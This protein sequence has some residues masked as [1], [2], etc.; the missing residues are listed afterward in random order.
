MA[1]RR[2]QSRMK[3]IRRKQ[4]RR[5]QIKRKQSRMKQSRRKQ[6]NR[7]RKRI[8]KRLIGGRF[9]NAGSE[10]VL[11]DQPR[12]PCIG[13]K[14]NQINYSEIGKLF[15]DNDK[16]SSNAD[17]EI[18]AS[19]ILLDIT[20]TASQYFVMTVKKC[21]INKELFITDEAYKGNWRTNS[22]GYFN[23]S[24]LTNDDIDLPPNW[25]DMVVYP[26][27]EMDLFDILSQGITFD[28]FNSILKMFKNVLNGVKLLQ[29]NDNNLFYGDF[30]IENILLIDGTLKIADIGNIQEI[31][32]HTNMKSL[33]YFYY[34]YMHPS[35]AALTYWFLPKPE[36]NPE[37]QL[38][39]ITLSIP[40]LKSLYDDSYS[41]FGIIEE[42]NFDNI[43][44]KLRSRFIDA[45][46]GVTKEKG[47]DDKQVRTV[48]AIKT[49]LLKQKLFNIK[50]VSLSFK[51]FILF[52]KNEASQVEMEVV[53]NKYLYKEYYKSFTD[54]E[55]LKIDLLKRIDLYSIGIIIL[56]IINSYIVSNPDKIMFHDLIIKLYRVVFL[57]CNQMNPLCD[58]NKI[59]ETYNYIIDEMNNPE[60]ASSK[61]SEPV[62]EKRKINSVVV[63]EQDEKENALPLNKKMGSIK[64]SISRTKSI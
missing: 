4:S 52:L 37:P 51:N 14:I 20:D 3:Q 30:S 44:D 18:F 35:I 58:I 13:E 38:N 23:N 33:P 27:G 49:E 42:K 16:G 8:S 2:K 28:D 22:E 31:N 11:Y 7:R 15:P 62:D 47:F 63:E 29:D 48:I 19:N 40:I 64:W 53:D 59:I 10:G 1:T 36:P 54:I 34:N 6:T 43:N 61:A 12:P 9:V 55:K 17:I 5:K 60:I 39:Q 24:I 45:F 50:N 32:Q 26:L 57:C 46:K 56:N 41:K 25:N 21:K